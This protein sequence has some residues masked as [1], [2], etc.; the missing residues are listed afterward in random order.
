MATPIT[1]GGAG[2]GFD[3]SAADLAALQPG[4]SS[5]VVGSDA[6]AG[7]ITVASAAT[8]ADPLTLQ[9]DGG[10]GGIAIN[11]ALS[12]GPRNLTL[13]SGGAISQSAPITAAG[14]LVRGAPTSVVT[15]NNAANA[16][17]TL[18]VD[19]PASFSF[20]NSGPLTLGPLTTSGFVAASNAPQTIVAANSTAA[21][22]FQVQTLAGN[23]TLNQDVTTVN[24]GSNIDLATAACS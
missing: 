23:L 11:A 19:P 1:I 8:F 22:N 9:N 21:G 20:V 4:F 24:A 13:S 5:I 14:L 6:H 10:A 12:N 2:T 18:S 3:L 16:V 15:L 7:A 17:G